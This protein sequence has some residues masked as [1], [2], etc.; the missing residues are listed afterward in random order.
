MD[1]QDLQELQYITPTANVPSILQ[2]G[3]LSHNRVAALPHDSVAMQEIQ[4]LR[5]NKAIPNARRLHDYANLYIC[6]RNPMLYKRLD[7]HAEL[8]V[9]RISLNVLDLPGVIVSDSNAASDYVRFAPAP[10]GLSIVDRARTFA[11]DWTSA[12]RIEYYRKKA[13]KCA[14]VLVPDRV[15]PCHILGAYV[16]CEGALARF[17]ALGTGL[18]AA[19]N[20]HTFFF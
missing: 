15:D 18:E 9:L 4:E 5:V 16:S 3:I 17:N 2:R 19:I 20:R 14:E 13:A 11:D 7:R 1:R 8:C 10:G 6:A 12:D